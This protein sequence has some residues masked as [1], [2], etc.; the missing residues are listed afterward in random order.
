MKALIALLCMTAFAFSGITFRRHVVETS[1]GDY[2]VNGQ[3]DSCYNNVDGT[4]YDASGVSPNKVYSGD[5]DGNGI[6]DTIIEFE[7]TN[8]DGQISEGDK[9]YKVEWVGGV[10]GGFV[11]SVSTVTSTMG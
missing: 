6:D 1:S 5:T 7:D 3:G 4:S 11:T 2:Y 9:V 10:F 8:L